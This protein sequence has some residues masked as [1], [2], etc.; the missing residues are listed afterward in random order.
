MSQRSNLRE[1]LSFDFIQFA[2][3]A[4]HLPVL[5]VFQIPFHE[6]ASDG[7]T[8]IGRK[9]GNS[10]S[11]SDITVGIFINDFMRRSPFLPFKENGMERHRRRRR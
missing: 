9:E 3:R 8:V 5:R 7:I 11:L 6:T 2:K 4:K 1:D 10:R